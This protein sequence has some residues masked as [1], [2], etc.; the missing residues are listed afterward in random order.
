M[1]Q[2]GLEL[3]LLRNAFYR[4]GFARVLFA[5]LLLTLVNVLLGVAIV[6]K[7]TH[8]AKPQYFATN[9]VGRMIKWHPLTDPVVPNDFVIQWATNATRKAFALDYIHYKQQLQDAASSFTPEGWR[10]F[11]A[12]LRKSN[13]LKTLIN[14][15]M[16]SN[17]AITGAPRITNQAVVDGRY[18]WVVKVPILVTYQNGQRSI[19][20]PMI[21]TEVVVRMPVQKDPERIA[22]NNFLPV[23]QSEA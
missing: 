12:S 1:A 17:A 19:P 2:K 10:Y 3:V 22:I 11:V 23:V 14:L 13:N 9:A 20:M 21:V 16:V 4:D 18:A 5:V 6:Y 7:Y 8:P 15:K